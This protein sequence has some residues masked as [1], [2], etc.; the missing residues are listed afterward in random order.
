[1]SW[2]MRA[3]S[4]GTGRGC[5]RL[6]G[7]LRARLFTAALPLSAPRGREGIAG[8]SDPIEGDAQRLSARRTGG[9][10]LG[11]GEVPPANHVT[12]ASADLGSAGLVELRVDRARRLR[13]HAGNAL[14]LLLRRC[15]EPL[16]GSEV[17][18]DRAPARG[19]DALQVVEDRAERARLAPLPVESD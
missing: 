4:V 7:M 17:L 12:P 19:P 16:G 15:E 14:E 10:G 1:R 8:A 18:Q 6:A 5:G 2:R 3:P 11:N 9:G 13:R